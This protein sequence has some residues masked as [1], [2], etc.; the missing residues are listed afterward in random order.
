[1]LQK[2]STQRFTS[3]P[4]L[5]AAVLPPSPYYSLDAAG[6]ST[7]CEAQ[8]AMFACMPHGVMS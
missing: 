2:Y 4:F 3:S 6:R 8:S 5:S 7:A 1:M